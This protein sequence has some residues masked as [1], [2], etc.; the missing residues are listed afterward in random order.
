LVGAEKRYIS[1][2]EKREIK[3]YTNTKQAELRYDIDRGTEPIYI[4][5]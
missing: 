3:A 2:M 5:T 4:V 1:D